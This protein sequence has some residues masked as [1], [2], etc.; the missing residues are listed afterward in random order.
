M[1]RPNPLHVEQVQVLPGLTGTA[2]ELRIISGGTPAQAATLATWFLRCPGQ[3][4]AWDRYLLSIIHLRD[5]PGV[6]P[7][8][9][10]V[11]GATHEVLL[12]AL[13]PEPDPQPTAPDSWRFLHPHN[14]ME[15]VQLPHDTAAIELLAKC[16][17]AV[18]AG[19]LPAEPMLAGAVEPWR[20]TLI[21]SAAHMRGE[22]HAP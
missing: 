16:A 15:Q 13:D 22:E 14:V 21:R 10:R 6:P 8:E 1:T 7:A 12:F 18:L 17:Q 9:V 11:P 4:P 2:T 3:S 20:T 5:L 19:I